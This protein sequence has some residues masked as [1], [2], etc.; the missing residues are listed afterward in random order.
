MTTKAKHT[1]RPWR[2]DDGQILAAKSGDDVEVA[3]VTTDYDALS[4]SD[5]IPVTEARA[6]ARLIAEAP[7]MLEFIE[8]VLVG[9]HGCC[10]CEGEKGDS[11]CT[12]CRGRDLVARA[13]GGVA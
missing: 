11:R 3:L 13:T 8:R 2:A 9:W 6:N 4:D 1:R 10:G 12:G 7:E 5:R